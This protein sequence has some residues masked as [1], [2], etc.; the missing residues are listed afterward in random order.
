MDS[1]VVTKEAVRQSKADGL[2]E[3]RRVGGDYLRGYVALS[4]ISIGRKV[5]RADLVKDLPG[6]AGEE[7]LENLGLS[8]DIFEAM[9]NAG[10]SRFRDQSIEELVMADLS[11]VV[12]IGSFNLTEEGISLAL[13]RIVVEVAEKAEQKAQVE[14]QILAGLR[15][16]IQAKV[17]KRGEPMNN[18]MPEIELSRECLIIM[19][20]VPLAD[21]NVNLSTIKAL[22]R[23][24]SNIGTVGE[25][26]RQSKKQFLSTHN[27]GSTRS[28]DTLEKL[29]K[30]CL[31]WKNS[32]EA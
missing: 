1:K 15:A 12:G 7:K 23:R 27:I 22:R 17:T 16:I 31:D 13:Q 26:L 5:F 8:S 4:E 32:L 28:A 11:E 30:F 2:K 19:D 6:L 10:F 14:A 21:A 18:L 20:G 29:A 25:L 3:L 9:E 24:G